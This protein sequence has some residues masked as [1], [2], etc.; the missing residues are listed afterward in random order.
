MLQ[1]RGMDAHPTVKPS[2]EVCQQNPLEVVVY[3][4][5]DKE[6][7]NVVEGRVKLEFPSSNPEPNQ[8]PAG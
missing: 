2:S 3:D 7:K 1:A 8:T 5:L 6:M 4:M